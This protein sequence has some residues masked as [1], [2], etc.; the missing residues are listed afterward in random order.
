MYAPENID[1]MC[2]ECHEDHNAD[3]KKVIARWQERCPAKTDPEQIVCTDC[4]FEHRLK[5]R[6][7]WWNKQTGE[8]VI[9]GKERTKVAPDLTK[10]AAKTKAEA[11]NHK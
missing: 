7:V 10:P 1:K 6:T 5:F 3:A 9:R 11:E 8:L 4:H 2:R